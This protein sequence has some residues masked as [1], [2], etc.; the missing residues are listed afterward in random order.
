MKDLDRRLWII[1]VIQVTEILGFS[2]IL[3]FLPFYAQEYG[4]SPLVIGLI[5]T[6]FSL[7]Q[8][9]S[10]PILGS[11]SDSYGRR[12]MLMLSQLSTFVS[13]VVL[14]FANSLLWIFISR[15]IDGLLGS[16]LTTAQAYIS[17]ITQEKDRNR[18]FN[19][20]SIAFSVGF[21]IGPAIGGYLSRFGYAVPALVAAG[22]ALISIALTYFY[23]PETV[24]D[25]KRTP[26]E[27][28]ELKIFNLSKF[29]Q[30]L[31]IEELKIV[32]WQFFLFSLAHVV[33]TSNFALY[34][35]RKFGMTADTIGFML[36]YVG[37]INIILRAGVVPKLLDKYSDRSLNIMGIFLIIIGLVI[38]PFLTVSWSFL[39]V[40]TILSLG[41][42]ISRPVLNGII[43]KV[44][45]KNEQ[46]AVMG[47]ANSLG[48]MA[49]IVG[50]VFGGWLLSVSFPDSLML[51]AAVIM[52]ISLVLVLQEP[53]KKTDSLGSPR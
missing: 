43:S 51:V 20:S 24:K 40:I 35:D 23:L 25:K 12:P 15:A 5:L 53:A 29:T 22:I 49:Q 6:V 50:P 42:G 30:Y 44:A 1:F 21:L 19:L 2:L 13:F 52:A 11:L 8:F 16:N 41:I 10:A 45:P 4:A 3:P 31:K 38:P 26:F 32:L 33:W 39:I 37:F 47:V 46:G 34:G 9:V 17:D 48:S 7:F 18:A 27:I 28:S 14:G 36:A